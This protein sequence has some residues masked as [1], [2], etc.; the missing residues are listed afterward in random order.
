MFNFARWNVSH[1]GYCFLSQ[2]SFLLCSPF[3]PHCFVLTCNLCFISACYAEEMP[4][5]RKPPIN[6]LGTEKVLVGSRSSLNLTQLKQ[7]SKDT[8]NPLL[9]QLQSHLFH[10][11]EKIPLKGIILLS[12]ILAKHFTPC[13]SNLSYF[14]ESLS[15]HKSFNIFSGLTCWWLITARFLFVW[16]VKP[17]FFQSVWFG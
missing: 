15:Q 8:K 14:Y 16:V 17:V 5:T 12:V 4:S 6:A 10:L 3:S 11:I 9:Q 2:F 1:R 13:Q 7:S